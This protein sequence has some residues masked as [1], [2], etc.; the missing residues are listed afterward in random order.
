MFPISCRGGEEGKEKQRPSLSSDLSSSSSKVLVM[1]MVAEVGASL[2][3]GVT[4][5]AGVKLQR[6]ERRDR[7]PAG[8]LRGRLAKLWY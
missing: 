4:A 5:I 7:R 2:D 1:E 3:L 6:G 8:R